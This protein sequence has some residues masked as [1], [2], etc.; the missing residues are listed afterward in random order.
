MARRSACL[1][2]IYRMKR[3]KKYLVP[4]ELLE[5]EPDNYHIIIRAKLSQNEIVLLIDTGASKTVLNNS[6]EEIE[7]TETNEIAE[8]GIQTAGISEGQIETSLGTIRHLTIQEFTLDELEIATINL[9]HINALYEQFTTVKID[10]LIG[11]DF[12]NEFEAILNYRN[13][14]LT[15]YK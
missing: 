5:L 8:K 2:Y 15:L 11:S 4:I 10:G 7:I 13:Q 9:D 3:K 1:F 14:T 12:L 6:L